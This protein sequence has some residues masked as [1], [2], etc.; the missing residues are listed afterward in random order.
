MNE[1]A[2]SVPDVALRTFAPATG[3]S[4]H[5]PTVAM[6]ASFV[7]TVSPE[8]D[9]PP[10]TNAKVTVTPAIGD[11]FWS[12]TITEGGGVTAAP[13]MP[14]TDVAEFAA[15]AVATGGPVTEGVLSPPQL[16]QASRRNAGA[17]QAAPTESCFRGTSSSRSELHFPVLPDEPIPNRTAKSTSGD[18][19]GMLA[20]DLL[21]TRRMPPQQCY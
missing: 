11:P 13:T 4:V 8:T 9:P 19:S 7:V 10:L 17:N 1:T 12:F 5:E 3:P 15:N 16:M 20:F 2:V 18:V 14:V 6:P 21:L